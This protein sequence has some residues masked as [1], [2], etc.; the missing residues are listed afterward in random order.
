MAIA[1]ALTGVGAPIAPAQAAEEFHTIQLV[2]PDDWRAA[3]EFDVTAGTTTIELTPAG[4][5]SGQINVPSD[6]SLDLLEW[7]VMGGSPDGGSPFAAQVHPDGSFTLLGVP[8][9]EPYFRFRSSPGLCHRQWCAD[10]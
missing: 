2:T 8:F 1:L 4:V 6:L 9:G 3:K 7:A 10:Q 5:I